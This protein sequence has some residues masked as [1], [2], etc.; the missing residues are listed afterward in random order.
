MCSKNSSVY[1]NLVTQW[2]EWHVRMCCAH[3]GKRSYLLSLCIGLLERKLDNIDSLEWVVSKTFWTDSWK[4]NSH[5]CITST[6]SSLL[7]RGM[8]QQLSRHVFAR[9]FLKR[10]Y[11]NLKISL[12]ILTVFPVTKVLLLIFI[13]QYMDR[14]I[15]GIATTTV[16]YKHSSLCH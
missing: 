8:Y 7:W 5:Y 3:M 13:S 1:I 2:R 14:F 12:L 16:Y 11:R 15:I 10:L 9:V 6:P 4:E